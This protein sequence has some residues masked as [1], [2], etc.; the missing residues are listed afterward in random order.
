MVQTID[1]APREKILR[2]YELM[3]RYVMPQFQGTVAATIAS[4]QWAAERQDTLVA[5]RVRALDR[6]KQVYAERRN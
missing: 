1:W 2:S 6:A 3:A 4:N 5:G